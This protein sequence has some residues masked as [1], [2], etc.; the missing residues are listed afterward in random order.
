VP[1]H[2]PRRGLN[3]GKGHVGASFGPTSFD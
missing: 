1:P 3:M 2:E